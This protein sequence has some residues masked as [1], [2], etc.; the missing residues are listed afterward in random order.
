LIALPFGAASGRRNMF[1]GVASSILIVFAYFVLL[2]FSLAA[3][4]AGHL[5]PLLAGWLPNI[6]FGL[7]GIW[8]TC[9]AR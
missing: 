1:V 8:L 7:V 2:Q 4:S 9:R 3:G 5:P 6:A